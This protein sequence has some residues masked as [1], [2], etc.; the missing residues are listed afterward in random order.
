MPGSTKPGSKKPRSKKPRSTKP[1]S[2]KPAATKP[3]S[4]KLS[5]DVMKV[6]AKEGVTFAK[7][8]K[9]TPFTKK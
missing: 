2:T 6:L 5:E 4:K 8:A 9:R 3:G 7:A 1:R